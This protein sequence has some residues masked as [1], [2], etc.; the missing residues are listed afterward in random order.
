[1]GPASRRAAD[2]APAPRPLRTIGLGAAALA[3]GGAAAL[4][5]GV[6]IE[7]LRFRLRRV[8]FRV[9]P[10]GSRPLRILHLSDFHLAPWQTIKQDFVRSLAEL[11]IDL[12]VNTGDNLG[13]AEVLPRLRAMLA[14]FEGVPGVFVYGS[15]DYYGPVPKNP[16]TYFNRTRKI[17]ARAPRLD[18]TALERLLREELGWHSL[19][20]DALVLDIDGRP[21]RFVGVDDPHIKYDRPEQ[22][23]QALREASRRAQ[24]RR[25]Q[26]ERQAQAQS[27]RERRPDGPAAWE[28]TIGLVHAPY[29]RLLD[30]LVGLGCEVVFAGHTHGG[31]VCV[32][33]YGAL[34]TNCDIPRRQA[35]GPSAWR[36]AGRRAALHVSQGLGTSIYAPIRFACPPEA[37][38]VTLTAR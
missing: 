25:A 35:A 36:H 26:E 24:E 37:T 32:P 13:H 27:A 10:P 3:A 17:K 21:V 4:A 18:V 19:N 20:N 6:F 30:T 38:L 22:A 7:R 8:E 29:T 31:Q 23:A 34:V 16:F 33:G 1:M 15:N 2:G 11:P 5:Y 28:T 12:V 9:L 14:P